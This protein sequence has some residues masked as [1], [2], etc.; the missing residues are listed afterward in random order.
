ML[1]TP[2]GEVLGKVLWTG[3]RLNSASRRWT[4]SILSNQRGSSTSGRIV[5]VPSEFVSTIFNPFNSRSIRMKR[6]SDILRLAKA[7]RASRGYYSF[8]FLLILCLYNPLMRYII[9][10]FLILFHAQ[11]TLNGFINICA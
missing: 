7:R 6:P 4:A 10:S 3:E 8:C 1:V 5:L 9:C 11:L 2:C